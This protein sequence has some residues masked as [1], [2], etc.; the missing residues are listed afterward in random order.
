ML[1]ATK[2]NEN[3]IWGKLISIESNFGTYN[4]DKQFIIIGGGE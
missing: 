2:I 3:T 1:A 4:L